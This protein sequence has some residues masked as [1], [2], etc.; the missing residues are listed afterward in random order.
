M[1]IGLKIKRYVCFFLLTI[2][3]FL[4]LVTVRLGLLQA[5]ESKSSQENLEKL[6]KTNKCKGCDLT[7]AN[8]SR[9]D[10]TDAD[11]E[12]ANL[13]SAKL[14]LTNLTRANLQN[15]DLR[16]AVLGG[17]D[18]SDADLRGADLRGASLDSA[19]HQGAKFDGEAAPKGR[20]DDASETGKQI[21]AVD[22]VK[23]KQKHGTGN[24]SVP[25]QS[26]VK[27]T[28]PS[29]AP[30]QV[31]KVENE[32][33]TSK[34]A[35]EDRP[36]PPVISLPTSPTAKKIVPVQQAIV[37]VPTEEINKKAI[38]TKPQLSE[39]TGK[40]KAATAGPA[41]KEEVE[42]NNRLKTVEKS[43]VEAKPESIKTDTKAPQDGSTKQGSGQSKS[44][45][46]KSVQEE[47]SGVATKPPPEDVKTANL[48]R[49]LDKNKCYACDLSGINLAGKNLGGA[50]LEKANLTGCNLEKA[51][52]D[53]ANL[54]GALLQ[55]ANLRQASLKNT[56]FYKADLAGADFTGAKVDGAMFDNAQTSSAVGLTEIIKDTK[57]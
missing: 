26:N 27:K 20:G 47:G 31:T 41:A 29:I 57:N 49:L 43:S 24:D 46:K 7:G 18:L 40:G 8:L 2:A 34:I 36:A 10:L 9:L 13:S 45:D 48:A 37:D 1:K 33:V 44:A 38:N 19:Y 23:P 53:D 17:T 16:S 3:C 14:S 55:K 56:D 11:L 5:A 35:T 21:P 54:K 39:N 42:E 51:D 4:P 6:K 12:G 32:S 25:A 50:D 22:S 30:V 52:L 15:A 28:L